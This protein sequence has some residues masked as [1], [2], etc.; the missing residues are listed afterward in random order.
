MMKTVVITGSARGFGF[1][2]LK[3]FRKNGYNIVVSDINKDTLKIAETELKKIDGVGGVLAVACDVTKYDDIVRLWEV[4]VGEFGRIDIF[5]NNAGINQRD[6]AFFELNAKEIDLLLDIDLKGAMIG[7]KI[8][9]EKMREQGFGQIYNVEGYG[10]NDAMMLGLTL[11]GTS[12]RAVTYFTQALAK[13]SQELTKGDVK[14][15]RIAPGIM[16]T[17]FITNANGDKSKIVLDEKTK[18]IYNILADYPATI[19][20]FVVN[21]IV[22]NTK[23]DIRINWLTN[24]RAFRKFLSYAFRKRNYFN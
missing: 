2:C 4:S 10:S 13:E 20:N 1:E 21:K 22:R 3:I 14:I 18:K 24:G 5:I 23:N 19:A 12:K 9:F 8:A 17:N 7:S 16:I 15:G 6:V 11:Y